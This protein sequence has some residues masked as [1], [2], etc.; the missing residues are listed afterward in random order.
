VLVLLVAVSLVP[1]ASGGQQAKKMTF[2]IMSRVQVTQPFDTAPKGR[3]NK[4]DYIKYKALLLTVGPLFG[5]QT[6]NQA[7]GYEEGTQTYLNATDA[8]V[9]GKTTFPGQGTIT[10]RGL[11]K[12]LRNGTISVPITGGT[13]KFSG[14][15]GV[16][17]IGPG[18]LT[19]LNTYR[20]SLPGA[21]GVA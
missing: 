18:D 15:H 21:G 20:L 13:G 14:A 9:R 19:S 6:K 17:I 1:A 4:G 5:K 2:S 8:R 11:M 12:S 16:L 3:E 10:Y 7:V